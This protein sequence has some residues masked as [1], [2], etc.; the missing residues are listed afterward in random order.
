MKK[1]TIKSLAAAALIMS[2]AAAA[3]AVP[4]QRGIHRYQQADGTT[5]NVQLIGDE[6][7]AYYTSEDSYVL[8]NED[9]ILYF[10][11]L[12]DTGGLVASQWRATDK[13]VRPAALN[14]FLAT[15]NKD[16]MITAMSMQGAEARQQAAERDGLFRAPMAKAGPGL[17]DR[18][19][20]PSTGD[21]K[22]L[23]VLVEYQDVKFGVKDP[24][25]YYNNFF[26]QKG[27][28][29][30]NATGSVRDFYDASSNGQ[31]RP[32]F[33]VYGPITLAN[34][35]AYYGA[36]SGTSQD[37][38][39]G[40]MAIEACNQLD[41][42]INFADYDTNNDGIIDNVIIY[43]AGRGEATGGPEESVWPHQGSTS[44]TYDGKKLSRYACM[45]EMLANNVPAGIGTFV[46]EFG[47]V[48]GLPDIYATIYPTPAPFTPGEWDTMDQGSYNND[49]RTPAL[50]TSFERYAL[51]W[52]EPTEINGT[53]NAT[54]KP[55][56]DSNE[57]YII[58]TQSANEY[59]ILENRQ[60]KGWDKYIPG[61]GMLIWHIDYLRTIWDRNSCSNNANHQYVD[62]EEADNLKTEA[63][64]DGDP[65]PGS[66]NVTSFG[67]NTTP[68]MVTWTSQR[69]NLPITDIKETA[70]TGIITFKVKGGIKA[71]GTTA[72][73]AKDVTPRSF[74]ASWNTQAQAK[75]YQLSVYTMDTDGTIN[76]VPGYNHRNVGNTTS[77][78]VTG[79]EPATSYLYNIV[80]A[81]DDAT[82]DPSNE[83]G[84][85]TLALTHEYVIPQ[86][87]EATDVTDYSFT[88]NWT[89]VEGATDY[90][91]DVY[92]RHIDGAITETEDFSGNTASWFSSSSSFNSS[93]IYFGKGSPS[94]K[95]SNEG[96]VSSPYTSGIVSLFKF[97]HRGQRT[98]ADARIVV[99][100]LVADCW[101]PVAYIP[102]YTKSGGA[103]TTVNSFPA[104]TK[105]VR[106]IVYNSTDNGVVY[107]DDLEM[108]SG[109]TETR[110]PVTGFSPKATGNVASFS[111]E[112]LVPGSDHF[113]TVRALKGGVRSMK[114]AEMYVR[115]TGEHSGIEDING[116][117]NG[118]GITTS[119]SMI[120]INAPA[121]L[122][123]AVS[124]INGRAIYAGTAGVSAT[125]LRVAPGIY[126]VTTGTATVK[127]IVR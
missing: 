42:Q 36:H 127:V 76:Y 96:Y 67:D 28:S 34:N 47:H 124:D 59:F 54:L 55:L 45:N 97:W 57:C 62:I 74:T 38:R 53:L 48:L 118:T 72:L 112:D 27:F 110:I 23:V 25:T 125:T 64:R 107:I 17:F 66:A 11:E 78:Q 122:P 58:K 56:A 86:V 102:V 63:T 85:N 40:E 115:T 92:S 120:T 103:E 123:V 46:H 31:F 87:N 106:V 43:Y 121:G 116:D 104:D 99:E 105:A 60:Q 93:K 8:V 83:I 82:S 10:A 94:I 84:F 109:G 89:P 126:L 18:V 73:A 44:G 33:D 49:G 68:S 88:A 21:R 2:S 100:A 52:V 24:A 98:A 20:F 29:E 6:H 79:L 91:L 108:A 90:E 30:D 61:H 9:G 41:A 22:V 70:P 37:I 80:C 3:Y 16:D 7:H 50:Y 32:T 71:Q 26:N 119:G 15:V 65:F 117:V 12:D 114:S 95:L 69:L 39:P 4:A 51:G 19:N 14:S 13:D 113:Y 35:M 77:A 101:T 81:T 5:V 1:K 111:V 75:S